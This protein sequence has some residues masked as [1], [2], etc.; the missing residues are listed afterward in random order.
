VTLLVGGVQ[1]DVKADAEGS[2]SRALEIDPGVVVQ[3][4]GSAGSR[5][6][7]GIGVTRPRADE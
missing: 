4:F 3:A 1:L 2:F 7:T 6:D 5:A